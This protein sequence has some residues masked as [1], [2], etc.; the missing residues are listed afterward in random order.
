MT[1]KPRRVPKPLA[2]CDFSVR[3]NGQISVMEDGRTAALLS[4]EDGWK[5]FKVECGP[6]TSRTV[7]LLRGAV[8]V[9]KFEARA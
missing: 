2:A 3:V 7:E 5:K 9:A 6:T 1:T 8:V 4:E